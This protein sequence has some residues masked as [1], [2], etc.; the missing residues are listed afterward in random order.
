MKLRVL[1]GL[2]AGAVLTTSSL[3][4]AATAAQDAE[5]PI[6]RAVH[7]EGDGCPSDKVASNIS[8]DGLAL[9]G[10]FDRMEIATE[11]AGE[12]QSLACEVTLEVDAPAGVSL[13]LRSFDF[14][15]FADL[16]GR[17]GVLRTSYRVDG[18]AA[19]AQSLPLGEDEDYTVTQSLPVLLADGC[20]G[21]HTISVALELLVSE[22]EQ[23][24]WAHVTVDSVDSERQDGRFLPWEM[25]FE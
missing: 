4:P 12:A 24:S 19:G 2:C 17:T 13:D 9:T 18:S 11:D 22:G 20:G 6:L 1:Q 5:R 8:P 14:R 25:C 3:T 15:G 23:G 16:S 10:L 21:T 7:F